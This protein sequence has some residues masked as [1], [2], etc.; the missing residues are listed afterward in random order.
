[1]PPRIVVALAPPIIGPMVESTFLSGRILLAMPGIG[2]PR[3][4]RAAIAMCVH[5]ENG[6]LGIGIG[7]V[8]T[9]LTLHQLLEQLSIEPGTAPDVPVLAGGPVE[10]QRGFVL[11]SRDW[12][13]QDTVDVAGRW[14]LS[15]TLDVLKAIAAGKG[16]SRWVIAL[17]YAGWGAGQLEDELTRHGWFD[18]EATDVLLFETPAESRWSQSFN[19]GGI[20][21]ALLASVPGRA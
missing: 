8:L 10:P 1:M 17:G 15:G 4:N 13:G 3:F 5:D 9:G 20:D 14:S 6:A 2:D 11:H 16:P 19:A 21:P 7:A 18:V 12:G